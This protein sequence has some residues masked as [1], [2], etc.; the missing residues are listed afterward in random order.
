LIYILGK[1]Q[2]KHTTTYY[3]NMATNPNHPDFKIQM[4]NREKWS[5]E[6]KAKQ[7]WKCYFIER[8]FIYNL[9]ETRNNVRTTAQAIRNGETPDIT[10]LTQIFL[11]LYDKVG[12][13]CDCPVCMETLTKEQTAVP[14]CGHLLCKSCK[15]KMTDCP[16]CR[17]KY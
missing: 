1:K 13:L 11:E 7:G 14:L 16:I 9:Q 10:H 17:K 8:D 5:L 12:E 15:E 6:A 2:Y 3:T 4:T